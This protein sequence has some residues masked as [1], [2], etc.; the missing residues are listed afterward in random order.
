MSLER[1]NSPS[2]YF[3]LLPLFGFPF[4]FLPSVLLSSPSSPLVTYKTCKQTEWPLC[5]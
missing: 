1:V 5:L 4:P 3:V 2:F